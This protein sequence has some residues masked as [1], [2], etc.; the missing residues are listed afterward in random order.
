MRNPS[1]YK[2]DWERSDAIQLLGG[3]LNKRRTRRKAIELK[4]N[5]KENKNI[6]KVT[7]R[8]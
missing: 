3:C 6:L 1:A 2:L 5:L 4:G 7:I 8:E